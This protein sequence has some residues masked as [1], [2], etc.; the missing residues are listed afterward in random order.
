MA[1]RLG[2]GG[3]EKSYSSS[4]HIMARGPGMGLSR[5]EREKRGEAIL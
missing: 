1:R 3:G 2:G 4:L 5:G